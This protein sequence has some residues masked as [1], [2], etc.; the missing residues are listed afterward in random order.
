V[1]H[2][3]P[4]IMIYWHVERK[5]VCIHSQLKTVSSSEV[6]AMIQGVLG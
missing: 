5:A 2:R 3:G 6:A 1:R 4:A